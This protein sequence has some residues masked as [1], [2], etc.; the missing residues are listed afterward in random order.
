MANATDIMKR[1]VKAWETLPGD[2]LYSGAELERWLA[3]DMKPAI[4][5]ARKQLRDDKKRTPKRRSRG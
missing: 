2:S 5:M 1:V 4:D 3:D